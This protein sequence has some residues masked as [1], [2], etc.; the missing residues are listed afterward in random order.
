MYIKKNNS[1][2]MQEC[3]TTDLEVMGTVAKIGG[4]EYVAIASLAWRYVSIKSLVLF[5]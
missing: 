3:E 1:E 4:D 5:F 2:C